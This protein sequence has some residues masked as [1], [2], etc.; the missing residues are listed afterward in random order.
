MRSRVRAFR[1]ALLAVLRLGLFAALAA[2]GG[3]D[4]AA[5][6]GGAGATGRVAGAGEGAVLAARVGSGTPTRPL[7]AP[8]FGARR[9]SI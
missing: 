7:D 9:L 5:E 2:C 3:D 1:S 4:D 8:T 6:G